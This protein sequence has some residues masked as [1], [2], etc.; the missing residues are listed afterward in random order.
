MPW[1]VPRSRRGRD[2]EEG[3]DVAAAAAVRDAAD[4]AAVVVR[5]VV[6]TSVVAAVVGVVVENGGAAGILR[7]GYGVAAAVDDDGFGGEGAE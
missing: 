6:V 2:A 3:A 4:A 5:D 7:P 1:C